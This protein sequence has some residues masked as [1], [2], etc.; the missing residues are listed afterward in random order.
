[1]KR[2]FECTCLI[3]KNFSYSNYHQLPKHGYKNIFVSLAI[4]YIYILYQT[5][6]QEN[7][8]VFLKLFSGFFFL[9]QDSKKFKKRFINMK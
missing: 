7:Q 1:M 8:V 6:H 5:S 9:N 3:L 2:N 4:I